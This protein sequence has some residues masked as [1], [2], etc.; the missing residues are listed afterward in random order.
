MFH[1]TFFSTFKKMHSWTIWIKMR[2]FI[3]L[4]GLFLPAMQYGKF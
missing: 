2:V 1:A 3:L 4:A